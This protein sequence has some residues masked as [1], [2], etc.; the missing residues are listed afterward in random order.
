MSKFVSPWTR[1]SVHLRLRRIEELSRSQD[2]PAKSHH[3]WRMRNE[4]CGVAGVLCPDYFHFKDTESEHRP[5]RAKI[6]ITSNKPVARRPT[7]KPVRGCYCFARNRKSRAEKITSDSALGCAHCRS[8]FDLVE[9]DSSEDAALHD[10]GA[11]LPPLSGETLRRVERITYS[12]T[13]EFLRRVQKKVSSQKR[14][15][16]DALC[17]CS[18]SDSSSH[19][20]PARIAQDSGR[21]EST[22]EIFRNRCRLEKRIGSS[23]RRDYRSRSEN[24]VNRKVDDRRSQC[25]DDLSNL[26]GRASILSRRSR[27]SSSAC[28]VDRGRARPEVERAAG[29]DREPRRK[30]GTSVKKK[31]AR[32]TDRPNDEERVKKNCTKVKRIVRTISAQ[33]RCCAEQN[34]GLA[35]VGARSRTNVEKSRGG[36]DCEM[37]ECPKVVEGHRPRTT[38]QLSRD[39]DRPVDGRTANCQDLV[40]ELK[41]FRQDNYFETHGSAEKL[42]SSSRSSGSVEQYELNDRLFPEPVRRIHRDDIIVTMPPCATKQRKRIHYFPRSIVNQEKSVSNTNYKKKRRSQSCGLTGHAIDL[43][44]LKIPRDVTNSL[45]LRY[46]KGVVMRAND[47]CK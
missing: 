18:T 45:A 14:R 39:T 2:R 36:C 28:A 1:L 21:G 17:G 6:I 22:T 38:W 32:S 20:R 29:R 12:P 47:I 43:G 34:S 30:P 4:S 7:R 10:V 40:S 41:K 42:V 26:D 25:D 5:G 8:K 44:I 31:S 19:E 16:V 3:Y 13:S 33:S 37:R 46:Q 15:P 27:R 24:R 9:V 35:T 23:K 11:A